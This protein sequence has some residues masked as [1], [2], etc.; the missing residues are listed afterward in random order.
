[1]RFGAKLRRPRRN[2][3]LLNCVKERDDLEA[4]YSY[5]RIVP[6]NKSQLTISWYL[7]ACHERSKS[8]FHFHDVMLSAHTCILFTGP[9]EKPWW[10]PSES[11]NGVCFPFLVTIFA[12]AGY[13]SNVIQ[14]AGIF[15]K[16]PRARSTEF[17][18]YAT[19]QHHKD[20]GRD[21]CIT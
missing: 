7:N 3:N 19:V 20:N 15:Q 1:M 16:F 12:F 14:W 4:C 17:Q 18:R 11:M 8:L 10:Y 6:W 2:L 5:S 13:F 9:S 21:S